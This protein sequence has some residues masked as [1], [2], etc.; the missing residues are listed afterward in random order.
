[1]K[2]FDDRLRTLERRDAPPVVVLPVA[3]TAGDAVVVTM[4]ARQTLA[5][6]RTAVLLAPLSDE[7]THEA[8]E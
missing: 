3:W 5:T 2:R 8:T 1:M 4:P 7:A 6:D